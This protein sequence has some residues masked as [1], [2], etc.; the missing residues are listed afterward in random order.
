MKLAG[1]IEP[2]EF[3]DVFEIAKISILGRRIQ[4][5][6]DISLMNEMDNIIHEELGV[7]RIVPDKKM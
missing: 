6:N 1:L 2:S 7:K 5:L 4:D 3:Q